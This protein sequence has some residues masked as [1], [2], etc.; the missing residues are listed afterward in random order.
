M[1]HELNLMK[2]SPLSKPEVPAPLA[3]QITT[4]VGKTRAVAHLAAK[5][6]IGLLILVRNHQL[7]GE[8]HEAVDAPTTEERVRREK[9]NGI[10]LAEHDSG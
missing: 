6:N 4:G 5:A 3:L 10:E 9:V 7:A 1:G 2:Q 8:I